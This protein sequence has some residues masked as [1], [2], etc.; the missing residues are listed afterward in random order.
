M[1]V[2]PDL[3]KLYDISARN[4][5][6]YIGLGYRFHLY[7]FHLFF[8]I[9]KCTSKQSQTLLEKIRGFW[10]LAH[11][12]MLC[13]RGCWEA[14]Q[15]WR[16]W[17][18]GLPLSLL[19]TGPEVFGSPDAQRF[20]VSSQSKHRER[21]LQRTGSFQVSRLLQLTLKRASH[22]HAEKCTFN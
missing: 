4:R 1:P 15:S 12:L 5:L 8:R 9:H 17:L 13:F 2:V 21:P 6:K 3:L 10:L 7:R 11:F 14:L 18:H 16:L 19:Q 22:R 20:H